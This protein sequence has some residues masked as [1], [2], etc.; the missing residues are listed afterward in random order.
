[1]SI[2]CI[3]HPLLDLIDA[4]SEDDA[5]RWSL[6]HATQRL[7]TPADSGMFAELHENEG[8]LMLP[9]GCGMNSLRGCGWWLRRHGHPDVPLVI[10][11]SV[12]ADRAAEILRVACKAAGL[13]TLF[14]EV[15]DVVTG[16]CA[17]LLLNKARTMVT[18][19][20]A[21]SR[22][23]LKNHMGILND[24]RIIFTTGF[25]INGDP[26]GASLLSEYLKSCSERPL[27]TVG[28]SA[29]WAARHP[30]L[31]KLVVEQAD[32]IF[33]NEEETEA[34]AE[35]LGVDPALS[36]KAKCGRIADKLQSPNAWMVCTQGPLPVI[37]ATNRPTGD[38]ELP[39]VFSHTV[40]TLLDS[41]IKDDL[42]AGDGF[43]GGFLGYIY[44]ELTAPSTESDTC[45]ESVESLSEVSVR[46]DED[47]KEA[48]ESAAPSGPSVDVPKVS[49]L[50]ASSAMIRGAVE[51]G[52]YAARQVMKHTGCM[53]E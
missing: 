29:T 12:G 26:E 21:T 50:K 19:L 1:M 13:T 51:E 15:P 18:E 9:G 22:F 41:A 11:G 37:C 14:E 35:A 45:V 24:A 30:A 17:A 2:L 36:I 8:V 32:I 53:Y 52:I 44:S 33:G 25:Y 6:E 34:F 28:L 40:R 39:P 4:I 7:A 43:V 23:R 31:V 47:K 5:T 27:L 46:G 10:A 48:S 38:P 20:G 49:K 3:D 16:Q 42:G